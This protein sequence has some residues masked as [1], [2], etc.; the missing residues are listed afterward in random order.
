MRTVFL[1]AILGQSST[2]AVIAVGH[3]TMTRCTDMN[4]LS[5]RKDLADQ[6]VAD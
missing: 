3:L 4:S 6:P 1:L 5:V 2:N